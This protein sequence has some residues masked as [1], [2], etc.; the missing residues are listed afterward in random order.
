MVTYSPSHTRSSA[1]YAARIRTFMRTVPGTSDPESA[2]VARAA[3][4]VLESGIP[5]PPYDARIFAGLRRVHQVTEKRMSIDGRLIPSS[6]GFTIE[7][8]KDRP[9]GRKNFT[10]AHEVAHTF[11]YQG[12]GM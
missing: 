11:F 8:R 3:A 1:S 5:E 10:C 2:I 12:E 7:L 6:A 4:L 9:S